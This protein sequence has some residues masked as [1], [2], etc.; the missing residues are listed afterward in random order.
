MDRGQCANFRLGQDTLCWAGALVW[1]ATAARGHK[2]PACDCHLVPPL[3]RASRPRRLR[4]QS[5]IK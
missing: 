1:L 2:E 4:W 5:K 3:C